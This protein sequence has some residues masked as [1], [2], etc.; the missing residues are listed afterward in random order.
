MPGDFVLPQFLGKLL[1]GPFPKE[2]LFEID[3]VVLS[4]YSVRIADYF[5]NL[6]R[7]EVPK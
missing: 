4:T 6:V 5:A 7:N 1:R 3:R 2:G